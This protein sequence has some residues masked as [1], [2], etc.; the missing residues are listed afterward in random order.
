MT[1]VKVKRCAVYCRKSTEIGL[2]K[3]Y[4]SL[5]A[6]RESAENYIKSQKHNGWELLPDHYDDGGYSGGNTE[7]PALKRL[8]ADIAAGKI[9]VLVLY[10]LDR[11]SRSLLDFMKLAE[12]FEKHNVSFVS[13]TQEINTSTSSGRMMLNILMTFSEFE[14]SVI[15]ERV[16]DKIAGAKR[17]GKYCGGPPILGYN[18]I[19]ETKKLVVNPEE[20]KIVQEA[21]SLYARLGSSLKVIRILNEKGYRSKGWTSQKS[22]RHMGSEFTPK[23]IHR[24]L[25]NPIYIGMIRHKENLY[26]GEHDGIID[27]ALWDKVQYLLRE[28]NHC[29]PGAKRNATESPFKGLLVCGYC[30]GAFGITYSNK[31]NRRYMYYICVKDHVRGERECPLGRIA[32]GDLDKIILR[33]LARIFQSPSMLVKLCAE[34]QEQEQKRRKVLQL[35]QAEIE[36]AQ[37]QIRDQIH[38]GGDIVSLKQDFSELTRQMAELQNELQSLGEIYSVSDLAETCDSIEAIWEELFPA[39]RYKL[40]HQVIDKITLYEDR[41]VMNVKHHGL[42][43]LILE[44]KTGNDVTVSVSADADVVTLTIPVLVKRWNGRKLI[45]VPGDKDF[46]EETFE[47]SALAKRLAQGYQ[48]LG[49]IESGEYPT[50]TRLAE[51]LQLDPSAVTKTINMVNLS[52]KIQK[53]LV[54]SDTPQSINRDKLFGAIPEDW[55]EQERELLR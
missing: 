50:I 47:P 31:K 30:G 6:Q 51:G 45:V 25:T 37:Q 23:I 13:V 36:K 3:D 42:K 41:L 40:A 26:E 29:E 11:L 49:M 44:L 28:N 8:M 9:D 53:M 24:I 38:T 35:Q 2:E 5:D 33:Q 17:R 21:F 46:P 55:E 34:L 48:W 12:F 19:P 43:S 54:E 4:N 14:R 7:R 32:A 15:T 10:K 27:R 39:E 16:L 1:E 22:R 20:A 18:V 52:P